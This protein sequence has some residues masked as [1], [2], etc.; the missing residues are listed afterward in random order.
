M[1]AAASSLPA[2]LPNAQVDVG[3]RTDA[4]GQLDLLLDVLQRVF[5]LPPEEIGAKLV[6]GA[7][8]GAMVYQGHLGGVGVLLEVS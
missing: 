4:Q 8:D 3:L 2:P 7:F 6:G 1:L 5:R